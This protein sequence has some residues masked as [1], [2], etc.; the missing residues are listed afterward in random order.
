LT[1]QFIDRDRISTI[2]FDI[3][4]VLV[5]LQGLPFRKEW[6]SGHYSGREVLPFWINSPVV[7]DFESGRIDVDTF[8]ERFIMDTCLDVDSR[9]FLN[10]LLTWPNRLFDGVPQML[11]QLGSKYR[12]AALSN[13][14]PLHWPRMMNE[15]GLKEMIPD[16]ISSHQIGVMKPDIKAFEIVLEKLGLTAGEVLF[17]DD[18]QVSVDNARTLGMQAVKV[19]GVVGSVGLVADLQLI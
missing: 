16:V 18:L 2:L 17:L 14:N 7:K 8:A 4:G 3:G 19:K 11:H 10:H 12:L 15:F 9:T 13:S 6:L 1:D 5:R